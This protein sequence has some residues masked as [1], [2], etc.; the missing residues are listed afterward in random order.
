MMAANF[1]EFR[2]SLKKFLDNV[3]NNNETLIIKRGTGK[4][5]VMMSL[6]EY[7]SIME[8]LHLLNSKANA[9]RLYESI[10]QMKE[11]NVVRNKLIEE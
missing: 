1:T 7:N 9:D 6:D 5:A 11:G 4:G 3:V 2:T 8:T 10:K